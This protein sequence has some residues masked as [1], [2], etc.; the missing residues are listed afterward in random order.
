MGPHTYCSRTHNFSSMYT[1]IF[2]FNDVDE[3]KH[4]FKHEANTIGAC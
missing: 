4:M 2:N 1:Y 3:N